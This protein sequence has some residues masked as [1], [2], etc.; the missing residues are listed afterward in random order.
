MVNE[1]WAVC[2]LFALIN[3]IWFRLSFNLDNNFSSN[4][5]K[6]CKTNKRYSSIR[7]PRST[8]CAFSQPK[9]KTH[10]KTSVKLAKANGFQFTRYIMRKKHSPG[11]GM[12]DKLTEFS[13]FAKN[14]EY[15]RPVTELFYLFIII[16]LNFFFEMA[17]TEFNS[18]LLLSVIGVRT[19]IDF[20]FI[21]HKYSKVTVPWKWSEKER[22]KKMKILRLSYRRVQMMMITSS[23]ISRTLA[24]RFLIC[25]NLSK[26]KKCNIIFSTQIFIS[27]RRK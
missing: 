10:S 14:V 22:E 17:T 3:V 24:E 2:S 26:M 4:I 11:E 8:E 12:S 5:C 15:V 23:A 18:F 13:M 9:I 25:S 21:G 16:F 27:Q 1:R 7:R 6:T 19:L 20:L